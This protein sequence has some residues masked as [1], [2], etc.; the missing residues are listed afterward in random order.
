MDPFVA[1]E[2][3]LQPSKTSKIQGSARSK[4]VR[5]ENQP[6]QWQIFSDGSSNASG[7]GVGCVLI[8]PDG[9]KMEK[10]TR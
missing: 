7:A 8:T 1:E 6:Q 9:F 4:V 2:E 3:Q 5:P 10:A